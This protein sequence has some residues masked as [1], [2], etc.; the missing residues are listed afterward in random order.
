MS[1]VL[2]VTLLDEVAKSAARLTYTARGGYMSWLLVEISN[3]GLLRR[4][5]SRKTIGDDKDWL[6]MN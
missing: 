6:K 2:P 5:I 3:V 4:Q 1:S